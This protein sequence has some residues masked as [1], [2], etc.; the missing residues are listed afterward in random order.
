HTHTAREPGA[1]RSVLEN[2][3][4]LEKAAKG[5]AEAKKLARSGR[6][7]EALER[8]EAVRKLCP[9][10]RFEHCADELTEQIVLRRKAEEEAA[11]EP[12]GCTWLQG[13]H[14]FGM[15][16]F[17]QLVPQAEKH[18]AAG[19]EMR[20]MQPVNLSYCGAPLAVVLD[21]LR[22]STGLPLTVEGKA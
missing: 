16:W 15:C 7:G 6:W 3:Q 11:A 8:L 21:D 18:L 1:C 22:A 19:V 12:D 4:A 13:V 2:L 10:S 14:Q 5:L 20:L 17:S 9:G